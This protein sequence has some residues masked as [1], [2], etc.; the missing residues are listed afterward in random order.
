MVIESTKALQKRLKPPKKE[1]E[2]IGL[3]PTMGALHQG[4][5]A[6]IEF[7]Y[8]RSDVV[9]V[10]IFI[11]P[12]QFN[13]ASDLE[14]YPRNTQQ[15]IEFLTQYHPKAIIFM[16]SLSEVYPQE[17]KSEVFDFGSYVQHMEGEF[18]TGHFNGVGSVLKRLF[19]I[20]K[21]DKAFFGE[22]DYQQLMVVKKLVEITGQNIE[23]I[24]CPTSRN[25]NGLAQSSRNFRLTDAQLKEAEL[26]FQALNK[27]KAM[28]AD[29]D[30]PSIE[31]E[32]KQMFEEHDELDLEYFSIVKTKDLL[33]T[34]DKD[35]NENYRGFIAAFIG[36]VRLIDN[37]SLN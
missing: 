30:I 1:G 34:Q 17:V 9:V 37:M 33:P 21:P 25:A 13:N 27:A 22:K 14:N 11:N 23:I 4:H 28:F 32:V 19:D 7:A 26:I 12:T 10:S 31:K 24:G 6:L 3:V 8:S 18:R 35:N 29:Y 36:D 16:P 5:S 20:V 2:S 15:D